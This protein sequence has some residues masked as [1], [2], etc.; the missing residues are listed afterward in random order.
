[1]Q[2]RNDVSDDIIRKNRHNSIALLKSVTAKHQPQLVETCIMAWGQLG[3]VVQESELNLVL[4]QLLEY[5]GS[6]NNI[7]S[8]FAFNELGNLADSRATTPRRL[9]EPYWRN[10]AYVTT[11][12]M[13]HRPQTSRAV[14]ELLQVSVSELLLLIQ[15]HALPW[16]VLHKRKDVIQKIADA[17][18][19]TESWRPVVDS[20][21]LGATL[22][23]LLIQDTG[24]VEAF[25]K[26]RLNEIS[27]HFHSQ[28]LLSL[29]QS[30]PVHISIELLKAA[31]E[32]DNDRKPLVRG[33]L[34]LLGGY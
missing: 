5:L 20:I 14:A 9:L 13:I 29:L 26:S 11:K 28:S 2:T 33:L 31:G 12:D 34:L 18:Q 27:P 23:L 16:L 30:D 7:V 15:T 21:N 8:A 24:D 3:K 32:A 10:L 19:E 25:T 1:M 4:L 6:S 17:R 22:A